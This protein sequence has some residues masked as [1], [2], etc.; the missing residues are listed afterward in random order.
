MLRKL[1]YKR[2][3][4][5]NQCFTHTTSSFGALFR[6][7]SLVSYNNAQGRSGETLTRLGA[8]WRSSHEELYKQY[9]CWGQH[10]VVLTWS[11]LG[12]IEPNVAGQRI[13]YYCIQ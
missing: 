9:M 3:H 12:W 10:S 1:Q 13:W 6:S 5:Y 11:W 7:V 8:I 4:R 2:V